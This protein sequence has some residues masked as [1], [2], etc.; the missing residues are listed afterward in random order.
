[1]LDPWTL[2]CATQK[3]LLP[4]LIL[5]SSLPTASPLH[6]AR[7]TV[8]CCSVVLPRSPCGSF[9]AEQF[10]QTPSSAGYQAS[11]GR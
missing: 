4:F 7:V 11:A 8:D 2:V 5:S 10:S 3:V 1:M 6:L 9:N